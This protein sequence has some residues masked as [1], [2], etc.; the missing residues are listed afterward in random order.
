MSHGGG[1]YI[2]RFDWPRRIDFSFW[3]F[4]FVESSVI[5]RLRRMLSKF[6]PSIGFRSSADVAIERTLFVAQ[7][8]GHFLSRL[9]VD[10]GCDN[11]HGRRVNAQQRMCDER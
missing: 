11:G 6:F 5:G 4:L 8:H 10:T 7:R 2:A 1:R 3:L 9:A